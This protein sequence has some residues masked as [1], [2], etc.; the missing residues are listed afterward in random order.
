M[1]TYALVYKIVDMDKNAA[2]RPKHVEFLKAMREAGRI[3][4][5]WKFPDYQA[6]MIQGF[7][8]CRASS[9]AEVEGWFRE[10]PVISSGARTFEVRDAEQGIFAS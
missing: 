1:T 2:A 10:D 5:A 8:I 4:T 6:G 3:E 9:K 7:V